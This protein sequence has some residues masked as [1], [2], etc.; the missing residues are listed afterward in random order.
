L[1]Q[2]GFSVFPKIR[3]TDYILYV[4]YA[5]NQYIEYFQSYAALKKSLVLDVFYHKILCNAYFAR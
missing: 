3:L 4:I 1:N 5:P 2:E